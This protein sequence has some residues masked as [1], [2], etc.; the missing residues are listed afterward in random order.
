MPFFSK[1]INLFKKKGNL[2][3][4]ARQAR[5]KF[6]IKVAKNHKTDKIVT[7]HTADDQIE[8]V[9]MNIL[10]GTG[11]RGLCGMKY[12][13][14]QSRDYRLQSICRQL[15]V[16]HRPVKIIRPFLDIW[17]LEIEEYLKKNKI[18]F[19]IDKSNFDL[20]FTRNRIRHKLIPALEKE[21]P[22]F[23]KMFLKKIKNFQKQY[24]NILEKARKELS[25]ICHMLSGKEISLDLN[26][27]NRLSP[28]IQSEIL[29]LA[30]EKLTGNLK[31]ITEI[32]IKQ[33]LKLIKS[34]RTG[35]QLHLPKRLRIF[36][37]YGKIYISLPTKVYRLQPIKKKILQIPRITDI[38]E[39][40][41]KIKST[42]LKK[43]VGRQLAADKKIA[44]LDYGRCGGKL[45][46]RAWGIGDRF[47]PLGMKGT[48]KLQDF[49]TDCK[50]PRRFRSQIPLV[51][52]DNDQIVWVA[53]FQID[54]RFK[55]TNKTKKILKLEIIS[56]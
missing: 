30:I 21:N 41:T 8:T 2:E 45:Y 29:R 46:I 26:K 38:T 55:I 16:D 19:R 18:S 27:L 42:I 15:A 35:L 44:F 39:I 40:N 10:R 4:V 54:N 3:E 56:A 22:Q 25:V 11:S 43:K 50:V 14:L 34:Q 31:N 52:T 23:K 17:R 28:N 49:F 37:D 7:A 1:K 20:R 51:V 5:Y 9:L 36:K 6:L 48:K 33:C 24:K 13:S 12:I 47:Q 53:G 32:N